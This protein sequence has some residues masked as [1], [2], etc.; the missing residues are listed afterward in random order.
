MST[1]KKPPSPTTHVLK[2]WP[3]FFAAVAGGTKT[4]EYRKNDRPYA[5]GDVLELLEWDPRTS[6]FTGRSALRR[7]TH[8]AQLDAFGPPGFVLLSMTMCW[9]EPKGEEWIHRYDARWYSFGQRSDMDKIEAEARLF[10]FEVYEYRHDLVVVA[11]EPD[12]K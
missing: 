3:E 12:T 1:S 10:G 6:N 2:C 4:A 8:V 9:P 7:I 11:P 5:V